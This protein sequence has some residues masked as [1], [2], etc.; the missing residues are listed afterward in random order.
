VLG[1]KS[2]LFRERRGTRGLFRREPAG[3]PIVKQPFLIRG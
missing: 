2:I 3:D 1:G